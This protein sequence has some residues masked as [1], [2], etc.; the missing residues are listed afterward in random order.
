MGA[1]ASVD[2]SK[3]IQEQINESTRKFVSETDLSCANGVRQIQE[4]DLSGDID[5]GG[6]V[7]ASQRAAL[8]TSCAQ[9]VENKQDLFTQIENDLRQQAEQ[10][11]G[12]DKLFQLVSV[13]N[14]ENE[15]V[16]KSVLNDEYEA[17]SGLSCDANIEQL[18]KLKLSGKI[19]IG[20]SAS[21]QQSAELSGDCQQMAELA[22][23]VQ[24]RITNKVEQT[25]IQTVPG[26][27]FTIIASAVVLLAI[28]GLIG[29]IIVS[30]S[31]SGEQLQRRV[32]PAFQGNAVQNF[33]NQS[34]LTPPQT[35]PVVPLPP[36]STNTGATVPLVTPLQPQFQSF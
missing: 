36:L 25:V 24:E 34:L 8:I 5:I 2:N 29:T 17:I 11:K 4:I 14:A 33:G 19:K 22:R 20:G 31:D 23:S 32:F 16:I 26:G 6:D 10:E 27:I 18:Q 30:Y 7:I 12:T 9:Q 1:A 3:N 21:F 28:I 35:A 13:S 15:S